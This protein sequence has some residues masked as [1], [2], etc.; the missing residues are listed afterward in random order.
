MSPTAVKLLQ[1]EL[2]PAQLYPVFKDNDVYSLEVLSMSFIKPC[3]H[4][5]PL[6]ILNFDPK[7]SP[8]QPHCIN[9]KR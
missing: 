1:S 9:L 3:L 2:H 4:W 5:P 6:A 8:V 7:Y